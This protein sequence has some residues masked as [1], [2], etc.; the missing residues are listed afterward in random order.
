MKV[1]LSGK[2]PTGSVSMRLVI[3][4]Q[5]GGQVGIAAVVCDPV[6]RVQQLLGLVSADQGRGASVEDSP[7]HA[8]GCGDLLETGGKY[9]GG[10]TKTASTKSQGLSLDGRLY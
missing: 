1:F 4:K 10:S 9:Q 3:C 2:Q 8:R 6:L 5:R 7:R